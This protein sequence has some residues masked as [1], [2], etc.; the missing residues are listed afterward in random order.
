MNRNIDISEVILRPERLLLRPW[1]A[2]DLQ[3]FFEYAS[4]DSVG[5]PAGWLPHKNID[6]SRTILKMFIDEKYA[7][8][9]GTTRSIVKS[10]GMNGRSS[11]TAIWKPMTARSV[12]TCVLM[13]DRGLILSL[14]SMRELL[15]GRWKS[16]VSRRI[17]AT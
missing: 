5:Q 4:V 13:S 6:E 7:R 3:D 15:S 16:G 2:E 8:L 9:T 10:G 12:W 17:S 11:R 1:K 14:L